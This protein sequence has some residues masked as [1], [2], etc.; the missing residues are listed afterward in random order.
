MSQSVLI[1]DDDYDLRTTLGDAMQ[2]MCDVECI[3]VPDVPSMIALGDRTLGCSLALIDVNLGP[4]QP[5]GLDAY[6]WLV[7]RGFAGRIVFLTGHARVHT[8]IQETVRDG[9]AEVVQKPA[10]LKRLCGMLEGAAG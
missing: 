1:V 2:L 8:E 9:K 10:S 6:R 7:E 3:T 5:S 4:G